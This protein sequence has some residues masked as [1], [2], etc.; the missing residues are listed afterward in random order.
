MRVVARIIAK[1]EHVEPVKEI[2]QGL[3]QPSRDEPGC[4]NYLL[5]QNLGDPTDFTFVEL[6]RDVKAFEGHLG[7]AHVKNALARMD[8]LLQAPP[9]IRRYHVVA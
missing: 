7:T 8:G 9:D 2:L 6:W 1:P 5:M 4:L 3:I